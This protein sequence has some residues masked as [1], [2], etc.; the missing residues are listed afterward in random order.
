M[1]SPPDMSLFRVTDSVDEAA[2]EVTSF[3]RGYHSMRYVGPDLVLRLQRPLTDANLAQIRGDFGDI[4]ESGTFE[5]IAALP[6]EAND[7]HLADLPRLRFRFDR[8]NLGR[9]RMLIDRINAYVPAGAA[10]GDHR[11]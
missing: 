4:L 8:K 7:P 1:I 6:A 5:Q 11:K 10:S 3:Y 2:K 9:L